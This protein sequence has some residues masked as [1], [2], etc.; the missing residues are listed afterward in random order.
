MN[1]LL[2][3][4][5]ATLLLVEVGS[6]AYGTALPGTEDHDELA[7]VLEDPHQVFGLGEGLKTKMHRSQPQGVPSEPGDTDRTIYSLRHFCRLAAQ[8][9][10]SI[11][12]ALWAPILRTTPAGSRLRS[13]APAF[14]S[15]SM[16]PRYQGYMRSQTLR[17]L[18]LAG[19]DHGQRRAELIAAHGYDTKYA[20]HTARLGYQCQE[21]LATQSLQMPIP[22]SVGEWLRAIRRGEVPFEEWWERVLKLDERLSYWL[23]YARVPKYPDRDRIESFLIEAHLMTWETRG[24]T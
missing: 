4:P 10:P 15:R 16:I 22:G 3:L 2:P 5:D 12:T 24:R 21:L 18:G 20:M 11:L 8:G 13:L 17:L 23:D 1:Q 7:V 6:T 14:I 19:G 9:N